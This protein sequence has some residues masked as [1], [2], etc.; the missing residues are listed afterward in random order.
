MNPKITIAK[1]AAYLEIA[2]STVCRALKG[3]LKIKAGTRA[4]VVAAAEELGY[5][6]SKMSR[7][8]FAS[9]NKPIQVRDIVTMKDLAKELNL[10]VS[11]VSRALSHPDKVSRETADKV[12]KAASAMGFSVNEN[13]RNLVARVVSK[14]IS[15]APTI[16]TIGRA[17]GLSPATVSRAFSASASIS[18]K[19][20][21]R[22]LKKAKEL[23]FKPN[24]DAA[25]LKTTEH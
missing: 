12:S 4:R 15:N 3:D 1:V 10:S 5:F 2:P 19:N 14:D 22:V 8:Q 24:H 13:A 11:T 17:L 9:R 20:R 23:N 7:P 16:Y 25:M 18:A 21:K 6:R